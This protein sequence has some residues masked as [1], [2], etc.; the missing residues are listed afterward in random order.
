MREKSAVLFIS[1]RADFGGGPEHLRLL[2]QHRPPHVRA[3]VACP[4]DYPYYDRYCALVGSDNVF[5]LPYRTFSFRK[6]WQLRSFCAGRGIAAIHSHGK[7]GGLYAR[8][9]SCLT[10]L[11]CFHTFHGVHMDEYGPLTKRL[12]RLYER[13]MAVVTRAGIA[14]SSGERRCILERGLMPGN[15]L[16]LIPNGVPMPQ[17]PAAA[18]QGPP[19]HVLSM[20][21][22]D[23]QKNSLF[24]LDVLERLAALDKLHLFRFTLI[25]EGAGRGPMTYRIQE[26]GL[27]DIVTFTGARPDPHALF[28]GALCYFSSSR[29]EGMPLAVLEAMAYGLPPVVSDVVGNHDAVIHNE[30]GLLYPAGNAAAA[31]TALCNLAD[32]PDMR[33]SLGRKAREFVARNH[34]VQHMALQ[35]WRVLLAVE[36]K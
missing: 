10:G 23:Y 12:Y 20:T 2:L 33:N 26:K 8:L 36:A 13:C 24:L 32:T 11:P 25:G 5:V 3:C 29:W 7:G 35:T 21:R 18:P 16:L 1:V 31:A 9:L 19:H 17:H 15:K 6:L 22:F 30:T 28:P 27:A 4:R 14:T 34:D